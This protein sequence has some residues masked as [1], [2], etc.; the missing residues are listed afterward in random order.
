MVFLLIPYITY[1]FNFR[2][3]DEFLTQDQ[4]LEDT[5]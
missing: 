2:F 5:A 1:P 3:I 4:K